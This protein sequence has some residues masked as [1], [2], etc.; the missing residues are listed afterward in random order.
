MNNMKLNKNTRSLSLKN[1]VLAMSVI[2]VALLITVLLLMH[3]QKPIATL[4]LHKDVDAQPSLHNGVPIIEACNI[5]SLDELRAKGIELKASQ[6]PETFMRSYIESNQAQVP[7]RDLPKYPNELNRCHYDLQDDKDWFDIGVYHTSY[8]NLEQLDADI[9]TKYNPQPDIAGLR[10]FKAKTFRTV[11]DDFFGAVNTNEGNEDFILRH[12]DSALWFRLRDFKQATRQE[13]LTLIATNF[14]KLLQKPEARV[15]LDYGRSPIEG[16]FY[17]A[18]DLL[19]SRDVASFLGQNTSPYV[20]EGYAGAPGKRNYK[21]DGGTPGGHLY[22]TQSCS[23]S[24]QSKDDSATLVLRQYATEEGAKHYIQSSASG[25]NIKQQ[26]WQSVSFDLSDES[27]VA[28]DD[29]TPPKQGF[30]PRMK[31]D[32][33]HVRK[34]TLVMEVSYRLAREDRLRT[35]SDIDHLKQLARSIIENIK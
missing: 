24:G 12:N 3:V 10:V 21:T 34:D 2:A 19:T 11:D 25:D 5:V 1:K 15:T 4:A 30:S 6:R 23:R 18:C 31:E 9:A 32:T 16:R 8:S 28:A 20:N 33:I 13:I 22:I 26:P 27:Y 35:D 17:K 29:Y 7:D 14:S